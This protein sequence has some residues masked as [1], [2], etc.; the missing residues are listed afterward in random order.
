[1]KKYLPYAVL[2]V[3]AGIAIYFGFF[4]TP[5]VSPENNEQAVQP[6]GSVPWETKTDDQANVTV[7]VTPLT[8]SPKSAEWKF[9][10]V[11]STHSVE[12]DQDLTAVAVLVDD[13]GKEY[14]PLTWEG[15][16]GGH[17]REGVLVFNPIAPLPQSIELRIK[18]LGGVTTRSFIWNLP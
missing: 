6:A 7:V 18:D 8:V 13:Q 5:Q 15:P 10:I 14:A 11:M 1:M 12:L 3:V 17:H 16:T 4:R 9:N 2:I